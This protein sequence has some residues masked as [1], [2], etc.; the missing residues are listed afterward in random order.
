MNSGGD[1]VKIELP[2]GWSI[3]KGRIIVP[4]TAAPGKILEYLR[5]HNSES[6]KE[7]LTET[8]GYKKETIVIAINALK[9]TGFVEID[10]NKVKLI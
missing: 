5:Q 4:S 8:L 3:K 6:T 7:E 1:G 9:K 2:S 10:D